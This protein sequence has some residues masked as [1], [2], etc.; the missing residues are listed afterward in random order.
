MLMFLSEISWEFLNSTVTNYS[1]MIS[2]VRHEFQLP[3]EK[4]SQQND[5]NN[6]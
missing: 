3:R 5:N 6:R 2:T 1:Q 4:F